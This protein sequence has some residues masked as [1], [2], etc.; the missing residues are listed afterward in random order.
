MN[1]IYNCTSKTGYVLPQQQQ[2]LWRVVVALMLMAILFMGN[3]PINA[4]DLPE[5]KRCTSEDLQVIG[6]TLTGTGCVT[7]NIGDPLSST[8][9]FTIENTT[10]SLRTAYAYW[11]TVIV[12]D[13]NGN[14]VGS[15]IPI[16]GCNS[17]GF[18]GGSTRTL[19]DA[20]TIN[21][22]CGYSVEIVNFYGAWTDA[23]DGDRN[24]CPLDP[25]KIAP[26]CDVVPVIPVRTPVV[27]NAG[28]DFSI[29]CIANTS[30]GTIGEAAQAG[31]TY[32]WVSS[33]V[34][35]TSTAAN[36]SVNPSVTTTYT[37]TKTNTASGCSDTDDVT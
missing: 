23:S 26:K 34:G 6:A 18:P 33:P 36:P 24:K 3:H 21:Y 35:F 16:S 25:S 17:D 11:G 37:V 8:I 14:P 5:A 20:T 32:S 19:T 2:R 1:N 12:K 9:T 15:P 13:A 29:T 28:A 30:G 10:G 22:R 4:Q 31:F 27:A 7:C